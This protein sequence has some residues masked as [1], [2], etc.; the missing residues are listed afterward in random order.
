M[1]KALKMILVTACVVTPLAVMIARV[2]RTDEVPV[3]SQEAAQ[4]ADRFN[5]HLVDSAIA[6]LKSGQVVLRTGYGADS[7]MLAHMGRRNKTYSHCGIVMVE[8]GYPFV[9]HSIGG[10]DNPDERLRRDSAVFFFSPKHNSGIALIGY[11]YSADKIELLR[12]TVDS[13]Y[14]A[15]PLFDMKFDLATDDKLYCTEFIYKAVNKIMHDSLYIRRSAE[16]GHDF[17]GVDD[18]FLNDHAHII[19]QTRYK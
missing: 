14:H 3:V 16:Y 17:V 2:L 7:Y 9:Y 11:D 18:L 19:W 4:Q 13:Y 12:K 5:K 8:H 6:M 1:N 10:E 15:R